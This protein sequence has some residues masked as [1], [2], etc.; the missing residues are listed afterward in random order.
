V[1]F[2]LLS[3]I[4]AVLAVVGILGYVIIFPSVIAKDGQD[5]KD[6]FSV[7]ANGVETFGDYNS[8]DLVTIVDKISRIQYNNDKTSVWVE[9]IGKSDTDL[10]FIFNKNLMDDFGVGSN[11]VITFEVG[12]S[13]Q[14]ESVINEDISTRPST[15]YDYIFIILTVTGFGLVV[16]G[17]VRSAKQRL[18]PVATQDDWGLPA[19]PPPAMAP[20]PVAPPAVPPQPQYPPSMAAIPQTDSGSTSSDYSQ[21]NPDITGMSFSAVQPASMT[22]T[23]PPGVVPGQVL[24]VTM[25]SGQ[26]VNVQVPPGCV[27]G[28]QFTIS[29]TQ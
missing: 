13:G 9:S 14:S 1:G 18:S 17:F 19:P 3:K 7:D 27:P 12:N 25:P 6:Q 24:T 11:V 20:A 23:V 26:V 2:N 10:R 4:G 16:F 21:M 29:V 8:G 5:F 22:I 28:S 15:M